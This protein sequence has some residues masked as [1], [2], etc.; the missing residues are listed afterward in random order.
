MN[1]SDVQT[2]RK[3]RRRNVPFPEDCLN[4]PKNPIDEILEEINLT[5]N[6]VKHLQRTIIASAQEMLKCSLDFILKMSFHPKLTRSKTIWFV[7]QDNLA[8]PSSAKKTSD[9]QIFM[10]KDFPKDSS[11]EVVE[12]R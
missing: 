5:T 10:E 8:W 6:N 12:Y 7:N 1:Q 3:S 4:D 9:T 11:D 2:P